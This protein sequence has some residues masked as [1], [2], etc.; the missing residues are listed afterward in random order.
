MQP[1]VLKALDRLEAGGSID[2]EKADYLRRVAGRK[3]VSVSAELRAFLYLGVSLLAAG[4]G[5]FVK[6]HYREFGAVAVTAVL[7]AAA[8]GCLLYAIRRA[9]PYSWVAVEPPSIVFD[10][11]VL[12]GA[13]LL[14]ADLA[15]VETQFR[16]L[17][18]G[19]PYHLL[20]VSILF[21][22]IGYRFDSRMVLSLSLT[23]FAAW[24][25]VTLERVYSIAEPSAAPALRREA[26]V[27]GAAFAVLGVLS[28]RHRRKAHFQGVWTN[29]GLLLLFGG[30]LSG[31]WQDSAAWPY[32]EAGLAGCA[33]A[34]LFA[35][36]RYRRALS[37]SVAL[38][39]LAAGGLKVVFETV[40]GDAARLLITSLLCL[41]VV[42][43][44][45]VVQRR[46]R[47]TDAA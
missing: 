13:L 7:S 26:I 11:L 28:R 31:I 5:L 43:A 14:A 42:A 9:P 22:L 30:L 16:L 21:L 15:Y 35:A 3:L 37:F 1:E 47:G 2:G 23:S 32:W 45:A 33:L 25:G 18:A 8:A 4:A 27:C 39:A 20:F 29:L 38:V 10:Y 6:E 36:F 12:L 19:W 46:F 41:A 44:I 17:G 34:A 40:R 24:R